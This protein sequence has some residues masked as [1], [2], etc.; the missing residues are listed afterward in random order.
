M[1]EELKIII[2][3]VTNEAQKNM[4]AVRKELEGIESASQE[5]SSQ[6]DKAM[7]GMAKS[8]LAVKASIVA[9][10]TALTILGNK[11]QSIEKGFAKLNTTFAGA[12][13]A[14]SQATD[15]YRELFGFLGEHDTAIEAAQSLALITSN[16]QELAEWTQILQGA[17]AEMGTKLPIDGLAEA[18]NET[19][20]T[21]K[22][23]GVMADALTWAKVS[24]D[25]FNAALAQTTSL[26][27]REALV[28]NTLNGLYGNAAQIYSALNQQTIAYNKS[29]ADLNVALAATTAYLTPLLTSLNVLSSTFLTALAPA[30]QTVSIYLTAFIQLLA[31]AIVWVANFF[32][33]FGSAVSTTTANVKGYQQAMS[34]YLSSIQGGFGGANNEI[35]NTINSV[36]KLK[37]ATMGF[38]E[39]NIV[40]SP[41]SGGGAANVP[42]IGGGGGG[43][44]ITPPNP[45]D[46]GIGED[47]VKNIDDFKAQLEAAKGHLTAILTLVGL[48][49]AGILLWKIAD[50]I[51]GFTILTKGIQS[52]KSVVAKVGEEGF[53]KAFGVTSSEVL[54][55][56][57]KQLDTMTSKMKIFG[58]MVLAAAGAVL[59]IKGYCD[60]WVNGIDWGNF[61]LM[62][63]GIG[64]IIGGVALAFGP[65]AAAIATVVGGIAL[66]V[67][68]IKDIITNGY[69]MEGVLTILAGAVAVLVGVL[70]AFN[71]ALLANPITWVVV[72]IMALVAAFV[73]LW[74]ECEGFRKFWIDLWEKAKALFQ[75][76]LKSCEPIFEAME[77]AFQELWEL[78]KVV[79]NMV[80]EHFKKAWE[81]IKVIWDLVKPYFTMIWENIKVIFSVV[82]EVLSSF[83]KAAWEAIK[84]I[85]NVVVAY[86]KAIWDSIAGI[87]SVVR[88]V[89]QGNWQGAWDAIKGI[90]GTWTNYFSTVW[91]S[92]KRIFAAVGTFFKEAFGA[93]WEGIK[94]IFSNVG[95]FF[96]G[97]WNNIKEIFSKAGDAISTA[98]SA[99]FK[100]GLNWVLEKAIGI[101]NGFIRTINGAI[102]ILNAIPGVSISKLKTLDVPQLAKGGIVD[103]ATLA[104]IGERGKE[105]VMPLENNTGWMDILADRIAARSDNAPSKIVL[106]VDGKE[107][108]YAAIDNINR[109]TKQTGNLQL[110]TI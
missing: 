81:D 34:N 14:A 102:S 51:N 12:G 19:I 108:G 17:F 65:M 69:S 91:D 71:S 104:V 106:M 46:Y 42:S 105:A 75:K 77:R 24:E 48:V 23:V 95:T 92:I 13:M 8:V 60:A 38:D 28:R 85:W 25:G 89:L 27:E 54:K 100:G 57:N 3:A 62:L 36:N 47:V 88:N 2:R 101:I 56:S 39:L 50:V 110:I 59:L 53:K 83:F 70:W 20:N 44:G 7:K 80:V 30:I 49:G 11:A 37:R 45:A 18:A 86:F 74:N 4:A 21:G 16:E 61:A 22:V 97:V 26:E 1:N 73:I 66:L 41:T 82:K 55:E 58:G 52:V 99:A 98:V 15:T 72:G 63:S 107:L 67:I 79:W 78:I 9:L 64:L 90:V 87:F 29:Q 96:T 35:N 6:V 40:S 43:A 68:G 76:F 84:A 94:Q 5:A 93:A 32:G 103:S 10:T 109:I 31:D 33:M